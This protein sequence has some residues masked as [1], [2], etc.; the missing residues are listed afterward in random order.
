MPDLCVADDEF[1]TD[2]AESTDSTT[3]THDTSTGTSDTTEGDT[4][5]ENTGEK[6]TGEEDT[7]EEDT[8]TPSVC[9]DA[10]VQDGEECDDGN[11]VDGDGCDSDC[12]ATPVTALSL[13]NS[14]SCVLIDGG[15]VRC[16]GLND[17]GQLGF[18]HTNII[19]DDELP[20]D[21]GDLLL[22]S[23]PAAISLG[24]NHTCAVFGDG[25]LGC[26]G[27]NVSGQLGNGGTDNYGDNE[28]LA[29]LEGLDFS[30]LMDVQLGSGYTCALLED[31]SVTCWGLNN[32]GQL[33]YGNTSDLASPGGSLSLGGKAIKL[34][35]GIGHTCA[36][37]ENHDVRCWGSNNVGQLGLGHTNNIGDDELPVDADPLSL[38]LPPDAEVVDLKLGL[39]HS[40][41]LLS[42]GSVMCWGYNFYGQLGLNHTNSIGDNELPTTQSPVSLPGAVEQLAL[43][44][45]HTCA[46]LTGGDVMCWGDSYAGQ[47]GLGNTETIGDNEFPMDGGFVELG[48]IPL[49][50]DA[51]TH[52]TCVLLENYD[53]RCWGNNTSGQLGLGHTDRIGDDELPVDVEPVSVF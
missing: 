7:G 26:W 4:S 24:G 23:L 47:L 34:A 16:W 2:G 35:V 36:L 33:G 25:G 8:G 49:S 40:C 29:N 13:G 44:A 12:T 22:P 11:A 48:G 38:G 32:F 18:G 53:V 41:A 9:G 46:L 42:N 15:R 31:G 51:G 30:S 37:L 1:G 43:G 20:S 45:N 6:D 17:S 39:Y 3:G 28:D 27:K 14:H 5:S 21:V 52:H 10:E 50:I 19:G